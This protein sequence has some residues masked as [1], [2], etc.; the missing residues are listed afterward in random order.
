[1]NDLAK[2]FD[3]TL[4]KAIDTSKILAGT[5]K[6]KQDYMLWGDFKAGFIKKVDAWNDGA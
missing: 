4:G 3:G 6:W 2:G 1:M 5:S